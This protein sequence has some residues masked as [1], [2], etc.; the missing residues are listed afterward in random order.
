MMSADGGNSVKIS[1]SKGLKTYK[2]VISWGK[3]IVPFF[4]K[5]QIP[6]MMMSMKVGHS[7]MMS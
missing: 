1:K 2:V 3:K 4:I 6:K 7:S 5:N